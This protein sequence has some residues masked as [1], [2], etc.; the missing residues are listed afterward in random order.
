MNNFHCDC[1]NGFEGRTCANNTNDCPPGTCQ[2]QGT[3]TDQ[4]NDFK[5]C[6]GLNNC[7]FSDFAYY[8]PDRRMPSCV[9][10]FIPNHPAVLEGDV[11]QTFHL[12]LIKANY[13]HLQCHF[14]SS[15]KIL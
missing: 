13:V 12:S 6:K 11:R 9:P 10:S 4:T 1:K 2:N 14:F 15:K 7:V 3:C 8:H 5:V